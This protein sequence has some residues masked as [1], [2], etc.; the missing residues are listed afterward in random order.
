MEESEI[1][2][3]AIGIKNAVFHGTTFDRPPSGELSI[4]FRLK[5]LMDEQTIRK[6]L[7]S[8]FWFEKVS[9]DGNMNRISG[10]VVYPSLSESDGEEEKSMRQCDD[11]K[12]VRI[13]GSN[14]E[15]K[16]KHIVTWLQNYGS[17]ESNLEEEAVQLGEGTETFLVGTGTYLAKLKLKRQIPNVIPM[18]GKKI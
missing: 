6:E 18:Q 10:C 12:E 2:R 17:I 8:N 11:I 7:N 1:I 9:K 3:K 14:Y 4:T 15:L 13:E 16:E 5:I